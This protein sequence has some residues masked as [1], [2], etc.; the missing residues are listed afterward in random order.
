MVSFGVAVCGNC[1]SRECHGGII[2]RAAN[3]S[4]FVPIPA[5]N[6]DSELVR[7]D[8]ESGDTLT[9][10]TAFLTE[11]DAAVRLRVTLNDV[12]ALL[13]NG[14]LPYSLISGEI[15]ITDD[16]IRDRVRRMRAQESAL[17]RRS[18]NECKL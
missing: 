14:E 7:D 9:V 1:R 8:S 4:R 11:R 2:S 15:R 16:D 13:E 5:N 3:S 10:M 17:P 12:N 6:F 18:D